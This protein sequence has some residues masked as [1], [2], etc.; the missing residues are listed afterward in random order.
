MSDPQ[1]R[2]GAFQIIYEVSE[3]HITRINDEIQQM[4]KGDRSIEIS[5]IVN[6]FDQEG[7]TPLFYAW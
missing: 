7:K 5:R 6:T 1:A 3:G 2:G 4:A